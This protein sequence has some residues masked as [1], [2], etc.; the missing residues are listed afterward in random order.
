MR[1]PNLSQEQVADILA[2]E[3]GR[4]ARTRSGAEEDEDDVR[5]ARRLLTN[6]R[7]RWRQ[8]MVNDA[9]QYLRQLIPT[10]PPD[11]KL[12]KQDVLR[13]AARYIAYMQKQLDDVIEQQQRRIDP[14]TASTMTSTIRERMDWQFA[15]MYTHLPIGSPTQAMNSIN[16]PPS[17]T[18]AGGDP[19]FGLSPSGGYNPLRSPSVPSDYFSPNVG[20][21]N[22]LAGPSVN[23]P[24]H[25][26]SPAGQSLPAAV[27]LSDRTRLQPHTPTYGAVRT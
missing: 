19:G 7:E 2:S 27:L 4:R 25:V 21:A 8:Q 9:F 5:Q 10:F 6:K 17:G 3:G 23:G 1:R 26:S 20:S 22:A 14:N 18:P 13:Q 12:S 11:K 15:S 16:F 24:P